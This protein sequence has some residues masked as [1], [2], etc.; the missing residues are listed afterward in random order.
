MVQMADALAVVFGTLALAVGVRGLVSG[1][2][3]WTRGQTISGTAARALG[4][5]CVFVGCLFVAN[6][7]SPRVRLGD[8][9]GEALAAILSGG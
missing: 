6:G 3:R 9:F 8:R 7:V 5:T 1:R 2:M 4:A